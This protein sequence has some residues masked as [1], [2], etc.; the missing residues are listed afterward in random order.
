M[1][2]VAVSEARKEISEIVSR[3]E[4]AGERAVLRRHGREVAA[5][6]GIVD[7][8]LLETLEQQ[9][10]IGDLRGALR[11]ALEQGTTT[12]DGLRREMGLT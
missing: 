4:Y 1:I 7:L 9:F 10:D 8:V 11:A 6:V 2:D 12:L 5:V 3:V